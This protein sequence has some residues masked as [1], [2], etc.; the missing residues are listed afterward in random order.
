MEY[1]IQAQEKG[2][3]I[4]PELMVIDKL[5]YCIYDNSVFIFYKDQEEIMHCYQVEN[6][7]AAL[8]IMN[9]PDNLEQ[10]L[11]KYAVEN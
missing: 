3:K 2:I 1:P 8:E 6:S 11:R 7:R 9:D 5:Y 10:I 4:N